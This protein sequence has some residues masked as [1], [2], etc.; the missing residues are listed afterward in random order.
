MPAGLHIATIDYKKSC[1]YSVVIFVMIVFFIDCFLVG[2][3][4]FLMFSYLFN[5]EQF[6]VVSFFGVAFFADGVCFFQNPLAMGMVS[7]K[8]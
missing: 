8:T 6:G 3:S 1:C 2:V 5:G 4:L 7:A